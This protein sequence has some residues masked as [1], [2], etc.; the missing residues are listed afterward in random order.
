MYSYIIKAGIGI[1]KICSRTHSKCYCTAALP[2]SLG[3]QHL[4]TWGRHTLNTIVS[5]PRRSIELAVYGLDPDG[6]TSSRTS[7]KV[8]IDQALDVVLVAADARCE[9]SPAN[10]QGAAIATDEVIEGLKLRD[11]RSE[12][13]GVD[14]GLSAR[15]K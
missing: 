7:R 6:I 8:H 10:L 3:A 11:G 2:L 1:T 4:L 9:P 5:Q 14:E 13:L 12:V 15:L